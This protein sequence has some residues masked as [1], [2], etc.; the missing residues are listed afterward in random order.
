VPYIESSSEIGVTRQ[1]V[2]RRIDVRIEHQRAS[3]ELLSL[4]RNIRNGSQ[5]QSP[6]I[7]AAAFI[8]TATDRKIL[9]GD[10]R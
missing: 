7:T 8:A 4:G 6:I 3:V 9:S 2:G 1:Q 5:V 10:N